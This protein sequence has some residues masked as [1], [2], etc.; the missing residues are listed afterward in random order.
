MKTDVLIVGAGLTGA[1]VARTLADA[2]VDCAVV[3]K[4]GHL[5]GNCHDAVHPPSGI[6]VHTYGPHLFRTT[7]E[8]FWTL[9]NRF[10]E[11]YE[12]RHQVKTWVDGRWEN[13]PVTGECIRRLCDGDASPELPG[14]GEPANF[15]EAALR[16]MPKIVYEKFVKGYTEKQWAARDT[17]L[18]PEL[19]GR[20]QVA[21]DGSP[22]LHPNHPWQGLPR[23]G[24][25]NLVER[26]LDGIPVELGCDWFARGSDFRWKRLVFTGP[27]DLFFERKHGT[28]QY[29]GQRFD[30]EYIPD[31]DLHQV[32][33]TC[34]YPNDHDYVRITEWK[35]LMPADER[36][37]LK[38]TVIT[39]E[40]P[41]FPSDPDRFLYPYP[42]PV[43]RALAD[44]YIAM[45]RSLKDVTVCGRLG[46]YRY[47]DMDHAVA[48]ALDIGEELA[49]TMKK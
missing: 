32:A 15:R 28:L 31:E 8:Q 6:R 49:R 4:R 37:A 1:V 46:H 23:G 35:H 27:I 38:G 14:D 7:D 21:W 40:R 20:F 24:F 11:F 45:A 22:F 26:M 41:F 2:G 30:H 9:L 12:Y 19:A 33:A 36:A 44:R 10:S 18:G 3:E 42:D 29:R 25:T 13:W 43:N 39:Y 5:A 17:D 16:K 34:N 48:R 47:Y